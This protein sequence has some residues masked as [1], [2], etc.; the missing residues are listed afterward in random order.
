VLEK[1]LNRPV[2]II[3]ETSATERI[4]KHGSGRD[5]DYLV[6]AL[7]SLVDNSGSNLV[8]ES[9]QRALARTSEQLLRIIAE[10]R[11]ALRRPVEE[12]QRRIAQLRETL[13]QAETSMRELGYL[14]TAEQH[15]LSD[16]F[17]DRRREFLVKVQPEARQ[18]LERVFHTLQRRRNGPA[19]RREMMHAA[20][21]IAKGRLLPWLGHE[22]HDAE[23]A[24]KA[25]AQRF[26][27]FANEFLN[28]LAT[29]G[30]PEL[31]QLPRA[32]DP[33]KGFRTRSEFHFNLLER[34]AAPASPF[35]L[36]ADF[37]LGAVGAYEWFQRDT[38]QFLNQLLEWN[39]ARVRSDVDNRVLE[40]R[41][42]LETEIRILLREVTAVAER[43]LDHAR[44][45]QAEG[46]AAVDTALA[47]LDA[48]EAE[49]A[50][51]AVDSSG[52]HPTI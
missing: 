15:H 14:F 7:Q 28:R 47:R 38:R 44:K 42:W 24:Y 3:F 8:R 1:R 17:G 34:I 46:A 35:R 32:L 6:T 51:L 5:W 18:E 20:Q 10:E 39:S 2:P 52:G 27:G 16:M 41:H 30:V 37:A 21:Q 12:S 33:E 13:V 36:I 22:E 31:A 49:V 25:V 40:S 43:A 11:Q 4:E 19:L 23:R 29:T 45:L 50:S 26:V 9:A 48:L